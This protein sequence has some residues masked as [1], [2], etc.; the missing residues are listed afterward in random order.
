MVTFHVYYSGKALVVLPAVP[1]S[2]LPPHT[3]AGYR[4][5][6]VRLSVGEGGQVRHFH[7]YRHGFLKTFIVTF[8]ITIDIISHVSSN[9]CYSVFNDKNHILVT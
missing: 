6:G 7:P 9:I 4:V 2:L 8:F 3:R 1:S 5:V